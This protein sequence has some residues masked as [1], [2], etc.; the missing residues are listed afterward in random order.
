M[1]FYSFNTQTDAMSVL[2]FL[3]ERAQELTDFEFFPFPAQPLT[4]EVQL[5]DKSYLLLLTALLPQILPD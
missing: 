1:D 3:S 2:P 4:G 5:P